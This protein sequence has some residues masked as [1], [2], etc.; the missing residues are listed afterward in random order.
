MR[1]DTTHEP[2]VVILPDVTS[3][4]SRTPHLAVSGEHVVLSWLEPAGEGFALKW[5]RFIQSN[6]SDPLLVSAGDDWF[7]NWADFPSVVPIEGDT[8]AA[9][10]LTK[11]PG[12]TYAYDVTVSISKNAGET[13]GKPFLPHQDGTAT[14]H[15]FVSLFP[16]NGEVAALWLDGRNTQPGDNH[17]GH[18]PGGMTLRSAVVEWQGVVRQKHVVDDLVCDCCQTDAA[19]TADGPI[20]VFRNRTTSEIRD[21]Y[22]SRYTSS[23]WTDPVAVAEDGWEIDGCPVNGPAIDANDKRVVTAW[24]TAANGTSKVR[25]A[26]SLDSGATFDTAV[27]VSAERP[28]GRVDVVLLEDGSSLVSWLRSGEDSSGEIC[29][30]HVSETG[31]LGEEYVVARTASGRMSGFPQMAVVGD[32]VVMAWTDRDADSRRVKTALVDIE[33]IIQR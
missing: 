1:D 8:W 14:E 15:G 27:D 23:T 3:D 24:F 19:V 29:L 28:I 2:A 12:G 13:W 20:V 10:W 11:R 21:I 4:G 25:Y 9:H 6:W 5:S 33:R 30:R 31:L 32:S 26:S 18:G 22:V 16:L 7:V 17:G